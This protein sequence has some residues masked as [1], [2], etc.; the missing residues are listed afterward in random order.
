MTGHLLGGGGSAGVG[1]HRPGA[2]RGVAPPTINLDD[3]DDAGSTSP[4]AERSQAAWPRADRRAEQLVRLRRPQRRPGVHRRLAHVLRHREELSVTVVDSRARRPRARR[5]QPQRPPT[6]R[7]PGQ[8][9]RP[10][11]PGRGSRRSSTRAPCGCSPR[12]TTAAR[13]RRPGRSTAC[14]RSRSP[15]TRT[16]QGGAMGT[17]GV[18]GR[19][20]PPTTGR[21]PSG[22]PVIG[23]W[24]SGGARLREGVGACTPSGGVRGHDPGLRQ[25]AADLGRARRRRRRRRVRAR[26]DRRGDPGPTR[27][28]SSSPGPTW[29][30]ASPAR[31][32]TW[33]ASAA[34]SRTAAAPAS[35]TSS[36][37]T[38][39]RPSPGRASWRCCSAASR[40]LGTELDGAAEPVAGRT[41]TWPRLLPDSPKRAYDVHPLVG[42]CSTSPAS[43]CT[44]AGRRTS[45][46]RSAAWA[47]GRSASSPTTRCGSA[48]AS[49]RPPPRRPP[50]SCGCATRFGVPLVVRGRRPR[51]PA[52]RRP[53]MGRRG[54]ARRQAP[55]RV[56]RGVVPRV[57]LVT[58]KA[59]GGAYI[60][61]NS[62]VA[63]RD[64]GL[65]LARRGGRGDGCGRRGPD[66]APPQAGRASRRRSCTRSSPSWRPSTSSIAGGAATG[67][68]ARRGRRG[69]RA[70]RTR[71]PIAAAIAAAPQARG[72]HGNIPL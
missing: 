54:P 27:A 29:C 44:P 68:A 37:T 43:S 34:R 32:S 5:P 8:R 20:S 60:A 62:R 17:A 46:P 64:Q 19:S 41:S 39:A 53:G 18:Q 11:I 6:G 14:P 66:P 21:R 67:A 47:V 4:R 45:S 12:R 65:R 59:Y 30:A 25:G 55:A 24:H 40:R 56:R 48:A 9:R 1:R 38:E 10:A 51:L 3:P 72:A 50:A 33:R 28:G 16:V 7:Q 13:S 15:A 2:A 61:M 26:P 35:S 31:T 36:P 23:L 63:G 71:Q 70:G 42:G 58:R 49:T 57:T 22:A 52:W 69:H